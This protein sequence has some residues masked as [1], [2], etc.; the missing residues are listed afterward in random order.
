V[1]VLS[2][3]DFQEGEPFISS[4]LYPLEFCL[5]IAYRL[6]GARSAA[7][8]KMVVKRLRAPLLDIEEILLTLSLYPHALRHA[9]IVELHVE[10]VILE[11]TTSKLHNHK[12]VARGW[13]RG[14]GPE[15]KSQYITS[16]TSKSWHMK[17]LEMF[18]GAI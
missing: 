3:A 6:R 13:I 18:V 15:T 16:L 10:N 5:S 8:G 4:L 17:W 7:V 11:F 12:S 2:Q 1:Q 9:P 14:K